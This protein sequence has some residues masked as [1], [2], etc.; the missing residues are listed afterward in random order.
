MLRQVAEKELDA[1]QAVAEHLPIKRECFDFVYL[2]TVLEFLQEPSRCLTAA[3]DIMKKGAAIVTLT[4]NRN[5]PWGLYYRKL[6][7]K[8]EQIFSRAEFYQYIEVKKML[9][10]SSYR[11]DKVLSAL[12]DLPESLVDIASHSLDLNS[13]VVLIKAIRN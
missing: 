1:I 8:G 7:E 3:S 2:V 11:V 12:L 6:A 13:G 9:E 5:S 4:I 10:A